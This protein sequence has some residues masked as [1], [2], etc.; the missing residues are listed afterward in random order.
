MSHRYTLQ[1]AEPA[2]EQGTK[3]GTET[4]LEWPA[5]EGDQWNGVCR[6]ETPTNVGTGFLM[7]IKHPDK[8]IKEEKWGLFTCRHVLATSI[9]GPLCDL[10]DIKVTFES[11]TPIKEL[12]LDSIAKEQS[13]NKFLIQE[14]KDLDFFFVELKD[15]FVQEMK[16][17][18]AFL[19]EFY[20]FNV[21]EW[22]TSSSKVVQVPSYPQREGL[23]RRECRRGTLQKSEKGHLALYVAQTGPGSSGAPLIIQVTEGYPEKMVDKVLA[24]HRGIWMHPAVPDTKQAV[25]ISAIINLIFFH[26]LPID[27]IGLSCFPYCIHSALCNCAAIILNNRIIYPF[28]VIDIFQI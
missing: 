12:S 3:P 8:K 11:Y 23:Q 24:I 21:Q 22:D 19:E 26:R 17:S 14:D 20:E 10:K 1:Y 7:H 28:M 6:M 18:G 13:G 25:F 4:A 2:T 27:F 5:G 15:V 9:W 16:N